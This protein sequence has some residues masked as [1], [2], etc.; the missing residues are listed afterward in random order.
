MTLAIAFE[1][2]HERRDVG[3]EMNVRVRSPAFLRVDCDT[4]QYE[5]RWR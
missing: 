1:K 5:A 2:L 4:E 3:P